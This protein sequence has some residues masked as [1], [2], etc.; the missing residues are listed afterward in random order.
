LRRAFTRGAVVNVLNPKTALF[1]LAFLPQ[2]VDPDRGGV[3][4]QAL[5]SGLVFVG[6]GL[7]SDSLYAVAAGTV[8]RLLRRAQAGIALRLGSDLHRAGRCGRARKAELDFLTLAK[9]DARPGS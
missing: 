2:F 1:F 3:W 5:V 8:G 6:L 9:P 4:S 7:V